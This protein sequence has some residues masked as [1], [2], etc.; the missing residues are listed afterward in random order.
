[1][2]AQDWS[3]SLFAFNSPMQY[4]VQGHVSHM[5][6]CHTSTLMSHLST[7]GF[8]IHTFVT[9]IYCR[10]H[11]PHLCHTYVLQVSPSTLISHLSTAGF[12]INGE[13]AESA[14]MRKGG[15]R[16]GDALI[17]T[18]PLGTGTIMA[19]AMKGRCKGRYAGDGPTVPEM[20][21]NAIPA[22]DQRQDPC[23]M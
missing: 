2:S 13:V 19:A 16:P 6:S 5:S 23:S 18:K 14:V 22:S 7:A 3:C 9:L 11:H 8:I 17:L 21:Q 4:N 15:L 12:T 10:F 20:H 1:M